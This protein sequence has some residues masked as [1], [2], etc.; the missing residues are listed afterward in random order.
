MPRQSRHV[1]SGSAS[2]TRTVSLRVLQNSLAGGGRMQ[3]KSLDVSIA[4]GVLLGQ[5]L[6][7]SRQGQAGS[8]GASPGDLFLEVAFSACLKS[9][10]QVP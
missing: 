2:A 5:Q 1:P 7:L 9:F 8:G 6:R 4:C 10:C 3:E